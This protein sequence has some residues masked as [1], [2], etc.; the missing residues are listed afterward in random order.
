MKAPSLLSTPRS[1]Q[2]SPQSQQVPFGADSPSPR[3]TA[4]DDERRDAQNLTDYSANWKAMMAI[5]RAEGGAGNNDNTTG[6]S[7]GDGR[8]ISSASPA[9]RTDNTDCRDIAAPYRH[10]QLGAFRN[11][12]RFDQ[13]SRPIISDNWR[14]KAGP[15]SGRPRLSAL[16][17]SGVQCDTGHP[18]SPQVHHHMRGASAQQQP[19]S[20]LLISSPVRSPLAP[21]ANNMVGFFAQPGPGLPAN[22]PPTPVSLSTPTSTAFPSHHNNYYGHA[23]H[24]SSTSSSSSVA[25]Y[26][27][28]NSNNSNYDYYSPTSPVSNPN[29]NTNPTNSGANFASSTQQLSR[30]LSGLSLNMNNANNANNNNNN[31]PSNETTTFPVT[32][33]PGTLAY[34]FVRPNGARTRLVP[35][36]MLPFR[37]QGIPP[38]EKPEEHDRLVVLP[39][40]TGVGADGRSCNVG[41]VLRAANHPSSVGSDVQ[42]PTNPT[43]TTTRPGTAT[44]PKR[45]KIYC[46][47]WVHEGVCAFTQQGCKYKHEMPS[48]RATQHQLGLFLGYPA[49]WKR[50]Q[51]ELARAERSAV[52]GP[53]VHPVG[54]VVRPGVE[55]PSPPSSALLPL[56]PS[57]AA[58][59]GGGA[60]GVDKKPP[61]GGL[62][63]DGV[64]VN[65]DESGNAT[66][67]NGGGGSGGLAASRWGLVGDRGSGNAPPAAGRGIGPG[68]TD[69]NAREKLLQPPSE[70]GAQDPRYGF[71]QGGYDGTATAAGA[72]GLAQYHSTPEITTQRGGLAVSPP[73]VGAGN[74]SAAWPWEQQH[75][76]RH[77]SQTQQQQQRAQGPLGLDTST[78]GSA[79]T[80]AFH[81]TTP[82]P[83]GPIAP[84]ARN[85]R[86]NEDD[87]TTANGNNTARTL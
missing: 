63:R 5:D 79:C 11:F 12:P 80:F 59:A 38:Q 51:A 44:A 34:C 21:P 9:P 87:D 37:L 29:I 45:A 70:T 17:T 57:A 22:P 76:V 15:D 3:P 14:N 53:V 31:N 67:G 18:V 74:T 40:P 10:G 36:D 72:R 61:V 46:D 85:S 13:A 83:F 24:P 47:K 54:P 20:S 73:G 65:G 6:K 23:H 33:S 35:V 55:K 71:P 56:L 25:A 27:G 30:N 75:Y 1:S 49:W 16:M 69:A 41:Q 86:Q 84:P 78:F 58:A 32:I 8:N 50:R 81:P 42:P 52:V 2:H 19:R 26:P 66:G 39:V 60:A 68:E 77:A 7:D 4:F 82:S 28:Y 64:D 48:D 43:T 62:N